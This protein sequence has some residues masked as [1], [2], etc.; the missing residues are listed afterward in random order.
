MPTATLDGLEVNYV[1]HGSDPALLML[2]PGGFDLMIE[3][4]STAGVWTGMRPLETLA[5]ELTLIAHDR[6]ETGT[7][8]GGWSG[9]R[10]CYTPRKAWRCCHIS[11]SRAST[12]SR[13]S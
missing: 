6:R 4:W 5:S 11:Y 3:K 1:T 13:P 8:G 10:G 9:C 2:A 7:S 12:G